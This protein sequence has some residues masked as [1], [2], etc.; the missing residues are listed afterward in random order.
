MRFYDTLADGYASY[1]ALRLPEVSPSGF[2]Y[3]GLS[4]YHT[5]GVI[6]RNLN[7]NFDAVALCKFISSAD[8]TIKRNFSLTQFATD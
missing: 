4:T 5:F 8:S 6:L 7:N 3:T 1:P 2:A